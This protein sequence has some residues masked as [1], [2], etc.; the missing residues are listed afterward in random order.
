MRIERNC[1]FIANQLTKHLF[2][3][4][5][6]LQAEFTYGNDEEQTSTKISNPTKKHI[7]QRQYY[8][9]ALETQATSTSLSTR[10]RQNRRQDL[11]DSAFFGSSQNF[12]FGNLGFDSPD[13]G[14]FG[15]FVSVEST[16]KHVPAAILKEHT[17][18][19][20]YR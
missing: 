6:E 16:T 11:G 1:V 3:R 12:N 8:D 10:T 17:Y 15:D 5:E 4:Y 13:A 2:F 14:R 9:K 7:R 19:D 18:T 20:K